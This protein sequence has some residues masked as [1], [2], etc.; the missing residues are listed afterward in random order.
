MKKIL[1]P[2]GRQFINSEDYKSVKLSLKQ[3]LITTGNLVQKF[4]T[5]LRKYVNAKFVLSCSS[6]TAALHLAIKS[7]NLKKGDSVILPVINFVAASNILNEYGIKIYFAD[8]DPI[9]GQITPEKILNCIKKNKIKK[10]K[11]FFTMYLGGMPY[12]IEEFYKLKK[13]LNILM[14]EDACH[15]LG[16]LYKFKKK[17]FKVGSCIHS[18]ICLFSLHPLKSITTGE[19]GVFTTNNKKFYEKAKLFRS[20][21]IKRSKKHWH[22]DVTN[23]GLNYR[24]SDINCALGISQLRKL[25]VFLKKRKKLSK[26]YLKYIAN[27]KEISVVDKYS[28]LSSWHLFRININ[29]DKIKISKRNFIEK[30]LQKGIIVQQHYI[31]LYKFSVYKNIGKNYSGAEK[32]FNSTVSLPIYYSLTNKEQ[33]YVIKTLNEILRIK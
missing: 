30:F 7:I 33:L 12:L 24:L 27:M 6:G 4:E 19:G 3:N 21:G 1:I 15:A 32:F 16:S 10:L 11:A 28:T 2:Y 17:L 18:D 26:N 9:T 31:P 23:Y 20:H 14:I 8:V 5:E 22:Y 29:F 25:N 13:K